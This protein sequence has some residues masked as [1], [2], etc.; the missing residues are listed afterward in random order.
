[1]LVAGILL[2]A[3]DLG[4]DRV[5]TK[6][7]ELRMAKVIVARP[8]QELDLGNST[9]SSHRQSSFRRRQPRPHDRSSFGI[10]KRAVLD[11]NRGTSEY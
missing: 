6:S 9:G 8:F 5:V 3:S 11:A 7:H 2:F 10:H 1:M 4:G